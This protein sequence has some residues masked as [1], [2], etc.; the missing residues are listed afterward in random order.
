MSDRET[1]PDTE[2]ALKAADCLR[3]LAD[4]L[5][6]GEFQVSL[7]LSH[8]TVPP[9]PAEGDFEAGPWGK[10]VTLFLQAERE[11]AS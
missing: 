4:E 9:W 5:E 10:Q 6:S 11:V 2:S 3:K 8:K 1:T 7:H